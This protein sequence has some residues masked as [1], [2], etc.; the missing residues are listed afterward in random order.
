MMPS[1]RVRFV[2]CTQEMIEEKK[3]K[4]EM[5]KEQLSSVNHLLDSEKAMTLELIKKV[6]CLESE[7]CEKTAEAHSHEMEVVKMQSELEVQRRELEQL[8]QLRAAN[9]TQ[10]EHLHEIQVFIY[11][12][13]AC[14]T[15]I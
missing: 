3:K 10:K 14:I 9:S 11:S 15:C 7:L 2:I 5:L 13:P 6:D 4:I 8:N 1:G 12:D